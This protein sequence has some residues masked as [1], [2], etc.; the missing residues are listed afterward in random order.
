MNELAVLLTALN[1]HSEDKILRIKDLKTIVHDAITL[2]N[3]K[4]VRGDDG[5]ID[6]FQGGE[7]EDVQM[8]MTKC[9]ALIP[10][11][12][13]KMMFN[14]LNV[15]RVQTPRFFNKL[16]HTILSDINDDSSY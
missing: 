3:D 1:N 7:I 14:I 12:D 5:E 15:V 11:N 9:A 6:S 13:T 16:Y 4:M 10:H 8:I 2:G